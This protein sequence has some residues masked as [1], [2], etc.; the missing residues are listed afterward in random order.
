MIAER[1]SAIRCQDISRNTLVLTKWQIVFRN[2]YSLDIVPILQIKWGY[3][4][5]QIEDLYQ[6]LQ[7]PDLKMVVCWSVQKSAIYEAMQYNLSYIS[8][9]LMNLGSVV[10]QYI[11]I[12]QSLIL[13]ENRSDYSLRLSLKYWPKDKDKQKLISDLLCLCSM[14]LPVF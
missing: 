12:E 8:C 7:M 4:F 14:T 3:S 13:Y 9:V 1:D 5:P 2:H 11:E 10:L 6:A